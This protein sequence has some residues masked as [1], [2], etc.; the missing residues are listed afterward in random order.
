MLCRR[1]KRSGRTGAEKEL[2][3]EVSVNPLL[4]SLRWESLRQ[5]WSDMVP[6]LRAV[7]RELWMSLACSIGTVMMVIARPWP[8]KMVFDYALASEDRIRWAFPYSLIKGYG[9]S[10]IAGIACGLLLAISLLWGLFSYLQRYLI[11][12]AG[13]EVSFL[14]RRRLFLHLQRLAL[15][16]HRR[17][18]IGDLVMRT[19]A[20]T[21]MMREMM[22]E[23]LVVS[24]TS[25]LTIVA[26]IG[27]MAYIDW[28]L[29]LISMSVLPL[30]SLSML[31]ISGELRTAVRKQRSREGRM[32]AHIGET[33]GAIAVVQVHGRENAE[34]ARFGDANKR[35]LRQ[36][37]RTVKLEASLERSSEIMIATG[38][39]MV[40]WF[41]TERVLTGI[42]TPG[43]LLVFTS[44]LAS[45][46]KPLRKISQLASRVSK[47]KVCA[48]RVFS[49]LAVDDRVRVSKNAVEAPRFEGRVSFHHVH[50]AYR[51]GV[52]VLDDVSVKVKP[53]QTLGI[54]GANGAGKSTLS[55]MLPRLFDPAS[56]SITIDGEKITAYTLESLR[57]QIGVVLQQ[58]ILFATSIRE[59]IA[60]GKPDAT[61]E[62]IVAAAR[63]AD[64]HD[65]IVGLKDG[66][67]TEV[68]ERGDTLS[69]GQRQKI[70][71]VRA[72]VKN[73]PILILDEPTAHL[74]ATSAAHL[75]RTLAKISH[76]KTTIRVAHRLSEVRKAR[77]VLVLEHGRAVQYGSHEELVKSPGWYRDTWLLQ[78]GGRVADGAAPT[79]QHEAGPQPE[80]PDP[81]PEAAV[82][83]P[84]RPSLTL[85]AKTGRLS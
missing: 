62:E 15:T 83:S 40:L 37:L 64:A 26:M 39:G 16:F 17:Q 18:R 28:Q 41:G 75:N 7:R 35:S 32:A 65:F 9:A 54:V 20:D 50:F 78:E 2:K 4:R 81:Q 58:P 74:D 46:Y 10:G 8:I 31:R 47:A 69:G 53:G 13:H 57:E 52:P 77:R 67:D 30:L 85:A 38:T 51:P 3:V 56:G 11:A 84:A 73:P 66:Y 33:L 23:A 76:G 1:A 6:Y 44:Y 22:V 29:T 79:Q 82:D 21:T 34:A 72:M 12:S 55:A 45:M 43:D 36:G 60:Y 25:V 61:D 48:E 24:A 70:A 42:L 63:L 71:I 80:A 5:L 49:L 14:L 27:V 59:N 68:G 19:T